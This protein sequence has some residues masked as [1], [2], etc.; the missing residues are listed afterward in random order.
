MST[1]RII[2]RLDLKNDYVVKGFHLEGWRPVGD[3]LELAKLY[4][5]NN[6][7]EII[8]LDS[9]ASLFSRD[10]ILSI[11][12]KSCKNIFV[13]IG[14]GGGIRSIEDARQ[15][16]ENGA[17]KVL[18]NTFFV[19]NPN[20]I[21][22]FV[23]VF[24]SQSILLSIQS[25]KINNEWYVFT[26]SG[27]ENSGKKVLDWIKQVDKLGVGELLITSIDNDGLSKG[28]DVD[29]VNKIKQ[30]TDLPFIIGGGFGKLDHLKEIK[31]YDL[32]GISVAKEFH[33]KKYKPNDLKNYYKN[34]NYE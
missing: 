22:K 10:K 33:N 14:I 21:S 3:P 18:I 8:F 5:D 15:I 19:E 13:P 7:D 24:G 9:V 6:V 26:E 17:D 25:K 27:R 32:S 34:L 2:S 30:V 29:I 11:L 1:P 12:K 16:L 28:F 4:Y 23:S 20:S 31:D